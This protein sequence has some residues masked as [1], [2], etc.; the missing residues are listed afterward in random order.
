MRARV[1]VRLSA[2]ILALLL[3]ACGAGE[4]PAFAAVQRS[5]LDAGA[6]TALDAG[7]LLT[8]RL[9]AR[10]STGYGWQV[11]GIDPAVLALV[12]RDQETASSL[13]G[14][15]V[16]V[17]HFAGVAPGHTTLLL[18]Y[19]RPWAD[20][21]QHDPTYT[22]EVDVAGAY[23]GPYTARAAAV[24]LEPAPVALLGAAPAHLD[25]CDPGDGSH[26][27]CTPVKDQGACGGCWAFA[28]TGVVENLLYLDDPSRVPDLSEQY[29][30]S[31][32]KRS[33][34]CAGG[35]FIAFDYYLK[36]FRSPP[37]S[38]A[39][40][41]YEADLPFQATDAAC[42]SA[43]HPHHEK[44]SS[45]AYV[46]TG[47][48]L[49]QQV[50]AIKQAI[51]DHGP[52]WVSVC[53]DDAFKAWRPSAGVFQDHGCAQPNHAVVLTGWDDAS[54]A[55]V[56][57]NSWSKGWGENGYMRIAYGA[58]GIGGDA[59]YAVLA[60]TVNTPPV[61]SAGAAQQVGGG[62]QVTLDGSASHDAEGAVTYAWSQLSGSAVTLSGATAAQA[63][64]TAP[65]TQADAALTFQLTVTDSAGAR[66]SATTTVTV[67]AAAQV[68]PGSKATATGVTGGCASGGSATIGL[69]AAVGVLFL[70][71]RRRRA[72]A[73][74]PVR[75]RGRGA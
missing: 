43:A 42:G 38:T 65:A 64:F 35:G 58:N 46:A 19:R 8:V 5:E 6:T 50:A 12:D 56:M 15:D 70:L 33:W 31:C 45:W 16:E 29:L 41:V 21:A 9:P 47:V 52:V 63:S 30:I 24:R 25:V 61:A 4:P 20:P 22:L 49:A 68:D 34:T 37:E 23:A 26:G 67:K 73:T 59:S 74:V 17:L 66:A 7:T 2:P 28:T 71:A 62:S 18:A 27:K 40:A 13:G 75:R 54:G 51:L 11:D 53:A 48:S 10:A 39:G 44:L 36:E 1:V 72:P 3:A 32:N 69:W 14:V 60:S 55:W 57:R